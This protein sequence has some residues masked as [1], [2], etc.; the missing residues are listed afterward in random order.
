M[1]IL[2]VAGCTAAWPV[3]LP[4]YP[5]TV[6]VGCPRS[7]VARSNGRRY[8]VKLG[9]DI[10][11]QIEVGRR[12]VLLQAAHLLCAGEGDH[13]LPLRQSQGYGDLRRRSSQP[14]GD[15]LHRLHDA[16]V[17]LHS[18]SSEAWVAG[19][20]VVLVEAL[21]GGER[22]G[23]VAAAQGSEGDEGG[24]VLGAPAYDA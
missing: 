17:T 22:P 15:G 23:Q 4:S 21:A 11:R 6:T 3:P 12:G 8:S 10:L 16:T 20:E 18:F 9:E 14:L 2:S 7:L 19:A 13:V 1:E 5:F 24:A